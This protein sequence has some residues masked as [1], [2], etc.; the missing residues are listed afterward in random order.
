MNQGFQQDLQQLLSD[1]KYHVHDLFD[2]PELKAFI[3]L[4]TLY[5]ATQSKEQLVLVSKFI[6]ACQER[7]KEKIQLLE[8]W[9]RINNMNTWLSAQNDNTG[10]VTGLDGKTTFALPKVKMVDWHDMEKQLPYRLNIS[11]RPPEASLREILHYH[12]SYR[13]NFECLTQAG[14]LMMMCSE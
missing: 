12:N 4:L 14:M 8:L 3:P 7:W 5:A 6:I 9:F 2:T 10:T 13:E 11:T 1:D